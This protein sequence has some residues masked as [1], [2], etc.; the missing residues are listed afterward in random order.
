MNSKNR[1]RPRG[2]RDVNVQKRQK[3]DNKDASSDS[4]KIAHPAGALVG[5]DDLA[6]KEVSLPDRLED[7]EGFFGLEEIDH[8]EVIRD[9]DIVQ[10]KLAGHNQPKTKPNGHNES[11]DPERAPDAD[12]PD[13]EGFDSEQSTNGIAG[14]SIKP[15]P[16]NIIKSGKDP[17]PASKKAIQ[18]QAKEQ[19]SPSSGPQSNGFRILEDFEEKTVD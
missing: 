9:G 5:I 14:S 17:K 12:L 1:K 19:P 18:H 6:W 2:T 11:E 16:G 7:A 15:N 3:I 13:W 4:Y 8:V 10:Y